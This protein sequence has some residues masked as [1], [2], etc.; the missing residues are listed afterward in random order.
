MKP[1]PAALLGD[2]LSEGVNPEFSPAAFLLSANSH[3]STTTSV[4]YTSDRLC[5]YNFLSGYVRLQ[6]PLFLC[7]DT[8]LQIHQVTECHTSD[9]VCGLI[10]ITLESAVNCQCI[11]CDCCCLFTL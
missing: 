2:G 8:S 5:S 1:S 11:S 10:S 7:E 9:K 3:S 6:Q 4:V